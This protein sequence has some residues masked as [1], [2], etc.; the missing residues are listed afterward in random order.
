[1]SGVS[2]QRAWN[3]SHG[4]PLLLGFLVPGEELGPPVIVPDE[5][6][7]PLLTA[8]QWQPLP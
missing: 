2:S 7:C 4:V 1:M 5:L 8:E 3:L 6:N